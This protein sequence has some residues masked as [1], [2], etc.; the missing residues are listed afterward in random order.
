M[1][2]NNRGQSSILMSLHVPN[3]PKSE[4][5]IHRSYNVNASNIIV[6]LLQSLCS[7]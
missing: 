7:N 4:Y 2:L 6:V 1:S 3:A 5:Q